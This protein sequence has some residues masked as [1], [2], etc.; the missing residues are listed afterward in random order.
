MATLQELR[1]QALLSRA[2]L[3][4]LCG[5]SHQSIY[6]WEHGESE[7]RINHIRKLVEALHKT[8]EEIRAAIKASQEQKDWAA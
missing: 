8:P 2:E 4:T 1:E 6:Y 7:P 3:A 5:V